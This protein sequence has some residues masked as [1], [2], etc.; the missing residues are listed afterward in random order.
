MLWG[1]KHLPLSG[2]KKILCGALMKTI[3]QS[4]IPSIKYV[5]RVGLCMNPF[6]CIPLKL[7]A[8]CPRYS[9]FFIQSNYSIWIGKILLCTIDCECITLQYCVT[10]IFCKIKQTLDPMWGGKI[11]KVVLNI[12]LNRCVRERS[13]YACS[14]FVIV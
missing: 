10:M 9:A 13:C 5:Q 11:T 14:Q 1:N 4:V 8:H 2:G 7:P 3:N 12:Y 6:C